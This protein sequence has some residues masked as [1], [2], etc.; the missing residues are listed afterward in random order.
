MVLY[1]I[2]MHTVIDSMY[3]SMMQCV[4]RNLFITPKR[5]TWVHNLCCISDCFYEP[6]ELTFTAICAMCTEI[7]LDLT[8]IAMVQCICR[9]SFPH[10]NKANMGT[11]SL[12]WIGLLLRLVTMIQ[13]FV[14]L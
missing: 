12:L 13:S 1:V 8:C 14:V 2:C 3:I 6:A 9:H 5:P 11:Q 7:V 10:P 4:H